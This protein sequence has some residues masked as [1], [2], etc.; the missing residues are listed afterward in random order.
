MRKKNFTKAVSFVIT[1]EMYSEILDYA[2]RSD[3]S[4]S[5]ALRSLIIEKF[6][7]DGHLTIFLPRERA[8]L[9]EEIKEAKRI[10]THYERKM[11]IYRQTINE[12]RSPEWIKEQKERLKPENMIKEYEMGMEEV[13]KNPPREDEYEIF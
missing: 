12:L 10:I 13:R 2:K 3:M 1:H 11:A 4:F 6:G 8:W 7:N 5:E 9:E